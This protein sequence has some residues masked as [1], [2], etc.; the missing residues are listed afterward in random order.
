M[1]PAVLNLLLT[2]VAASGFCANSISPRSLNDS[3]EWLY[4]SPG[5]LQGISGISLVREQAGAK[6]FLVVHDDKDESMPDEPRAGL[7]EVRA[8]QWPTY[9]RLSWIAPEGQATPKDL[10]AVTS[11]PGDSKFMAATSKGLLFVL[12]LDEA[13]RAL[14][15]RSTSSVEPKDAEI[16][17]LSIAM[18]DGKRVAV[19]GDRGKKGVGKL[20]WATLDENLNPGSRSEGIEIQSPWSELGRAISDLKLLS[21][22]T[23]WISAAEDQGNFGPFASGLYKAGKLTAQGFEASPTPEKR[24]YTGGHKIEGFELIGDKMI[25]GTDDESFGSSVWFDF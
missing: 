20:W 12:E 15:V 22:G 4:V 25:L 14:K 7:L 8:G 9:R 17:G 11:I 10:E 21:D 19:W 24:F 23:L 5:I 16:E 13:N 18:M 2:P 1:L 6:L 3:P